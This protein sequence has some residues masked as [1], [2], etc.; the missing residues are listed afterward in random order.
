MSE[1]DESEKSKKLITD[2]ALLDAA[3]RGKEYTAESIAKILANILEIFDDIDETIDTIESNMISKT[4]LGDGL[5]FN[6]EGKVCVSNDSGLTAE[7]IN[8]I[9]SG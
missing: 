3:K 1:T 9:L 2:T 4:D 6:T 7:E 8:E 5:E